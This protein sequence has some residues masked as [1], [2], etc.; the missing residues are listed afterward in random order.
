M[1]SKRFVVIPL[2]SLFVLF[3]VRKLT[4]VDSSSG[5]SISARLPVA[6]PSAG[7]AADI[8]EFHVGHRH[9]DDPYCTHAVGASVNPYSSHTYVSL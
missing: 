9:V 8:I 5:R 3:S 2:R 1:T 7:Y 4:G 6:D